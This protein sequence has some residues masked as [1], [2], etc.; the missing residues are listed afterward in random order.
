MSTLEDLF[1]QIFERRDRIVNQLKPQKDLYDQSL[2]SSL[3]INGICPPSWLW[4]ARSNALTI[5]PKEL[6]KE[7]LISGLLFPPL[8]APVPSSSGCCTHYNKPAVKADNRQ[9][10]DSL[11]VDTFASNGYFDTDDRPMVAPKSVLNDGE[12]GQ[13]FVTNEIPVL[14][15]ASPSPAVQMD[16]KISE[17][18]FEPDQLLA[19]IQRSRT[20][21]KA[22]ELRN[23]SNGKTRKHQHE[24]SVTNENHTGR[25]TRSRTAIGTREPLKPLNGYGGRVTRSRSATQKLSLDK[26]LKPDKLLNCD[27]GGEL[28]ISVGSQMTIPPEQAVNKDILSSNDVNNVVDLKT[29]ATGIVGTELV[30]DAPDTV[31]SVLSGPNKIGAN[32]QL[33]LEILVSRSPPEINSFVEPKQLVF[34]DV[35]DCSL[36]QGV[37][38]A[39]GKEKQESSMVIGAVTELEPA[40]LSNGE[41]KEK[42]NNSGDELLQQ[43]ELE[44]I[45]FVNS[46]EEPLQA[47]NELVE[48]SLD[49]AFNNLEDT[50][51]E[52]VQSSPFVPALIKEKGDSSFELGAGTKMEPVQ[53]SKRKTPFEDLRA[54][55]DLSTDEMLSEQAVLQRTGILYGEEETFRVLNKT[56]AERLGL[57]EEME[58][59]RDFCSTSYVSKPSN[60]YLLSSK[61][62]SSE[63]CGDA[64]ADTFVSSNGTSDQRQLPRDH[65]YAS[66]EVSGKI[67]LENQVQSEADFDLP[68]VVMNPKIN[69]FSLEK[70]VG[71]LDDGPTKIIPEDFQVAGAAKDCPKKLKSADFNDG[72]SFLS[73]RKSETFK[74][75]EIERYAGARD[76][77]SLHRQT[78]TQKAGPI[79]NEWRNVS[80]FLRSHDNALGSSKSNISHSTRNSLQFAIT[81][82]VACGISWPMHKRRKTEG[83][84]NNVFNTSPRLSQ[85]KA[86]EAVLEFRNFPTSHDLIVDQSNAVIESPGLEIHGSKKHNN[87]D[88][89]ESAPKLQLSS[90]TLQVNE[91]DLELE[92]KDQD[93]LT[94]MG[95]KP[96]QVE[97]SLDFGMSRQADG[98][99]KRCFKD[100]GD[101]E[102]P[103]SILL[104]LKK[105][106]ASDDGLKFLSVRGELPEESP[107]FSAYT[108]GT[109]SGKKSH[110]GEQGLCSYYSEWSSHHEILDSIDAA[111]TMHDFEG[112]IPPLVV[113]D[114]I[115]FDGLDPSSITNEQ[116]H[117]LEQLGR[118]TSLPTPL[119][120]SSTEYKMHS[121]PDVFRS[122]PN[123]LMEHM[124]LRRCLLFNGD[125][126]KQLKRQVDGKL[127][128][129]YS[130]FGAEVNGSLLG[131]SYSDC[132]VSSSF[133]FGW[134]AG[135]PYTPIVG[136][137][138]HRIISKSTGAISDKYHRLNPEFTCFR[139]DEDS[140]TNEENGNLDEVVDSLQEGIDSR[141]RKISNNIETLVDV[142]SEYCNSPALVSAGGELQDR[143]SL[144]FMNTEL[145]LLG[146]EECV[147]NKPGNCYGNGKKYKNGEKENQNPSIGGNSVRP[148]TDLH[149]RFSRSKLSRKAS[150]KKGS[151]TFLEKE[152]KI[153]NIVSN[154]SSFI[155]YVR[156]KQQ[157]TA[158]L[159]G[160]RDIK[161]KAL[162]AAEAAKRLEE[163]R[164]N[165]RKMRK[166]AAKIERA[167][168]EQENIRQLELKQKKNEEERKKKEADVA[169]RKRQREEEE[170]K[171]KERKRR[172]IE[173]VQNQQRE[174]D[175]KLQAEKEEKELRH[176]ATDEERRRNGLAQLTKKQSKVENERGAG[177][178]TRNTK[179]AAGDPRCSS[180]ICGDTDAY[181]EPNF[182]G[183]V[184]INSGNT[185]IENEN[186][187]SA[188]EVRQEVQSYEI[189]PYQ[190]SDD[191]EDDIAERKFIPSWA[192][193]KHLAR[194]LSSLQHADPTKI[195]PRERCCNLS[196]VLLPRKQHPS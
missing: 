52:P 190:G 58:S 140:C 1:M 44:M 93:R 2:A 26:S 162:E 159:T 67:S 117:V 101:T 195:F 173:K 179:I 16:A 155:P 134:D 145:K 170:R 25:V 149:N 105:R 22:L 175:N 187:T 191:E 136:K 165:E 108:E 78:I 121:T 21:Q 92:D 138:S 82:N 164:E 107:K 96:T 45:E 102:E 39:L 118:S 186:A 49:Q 42:K 106:R 85:G 9:L 156:Q 68:K 163:K 193:E 88:G 57:D 46:E 119:P 43:D 56:P 70:C 153:N 127:T 113:G 35:E 36:N 94:P 33:G 167:K 69:N 24:E 150:E 10:S 180:S 146:T 28:Q 4:T 19:R 40:Q 188:V 144:D 135:R 128:D 54:K 103:N 125:D 183:K 110:H 31:H 7:D 53:S 47:A 65:L 32:R 124:D 137:H 37:S 177:C 114:G 172:C 182:C 23:S 104:N 194:C 154:I 6:K 89:F 132:T 66:Q 13:R 86:S 160:K 178:R 12:L 17:M 15:P 63:N 3:I 123:G 139:I 64:L 169:E 11:I 72:G 192:R 181:K 130:N 116:V 158:V 84:L 185:H 168:L 98:N 148:A 189:S 157:S 18:Y 142:T 171:V 109:M 80:Y 95:L 126:D 91:G 133:Q 122:L 196:E 20:R 76:L 151:Q 74:S 29:C 131:R 34:D 73:S 41:T 27:G 61:K 83:G 5:D 62:R 81:N 79:C 176:K 77:V 8:R 14:D 143:E 87:T 71:K 38:P 112:F 75:P 115:I 59:E 147:K 90:L 111:E 60:L 48:K 174:H 51:M 99:S 141:K 152:S 184:V 55:H 129:V 50:K 97:A 100:R 120:H 166:E 161:V 30:F